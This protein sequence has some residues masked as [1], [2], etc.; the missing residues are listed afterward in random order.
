M[1]ELKAKFHTLD[2]ERQTMED[3]ME[4]LVASLQSTPVGLKGSVIDDEGFPR[5][6]ID[7]IQIRKWR[8]RLD[9]VSNDHKALMRTIETT[10]HAIHGAASD[11]ATTGGVPP[12]G[13]SAG[14]AS[15]THVAGD[16]RRNAAGPP[17][18][19]ADE[20]FV[21]VDDVTAGSPAATAGLQVGDRI[22]Q[23]GP[24]TAAGFTLAALGQLVA[25]NRGVT[26]VVRILRADAQLSVEL[27]PHPWAGQGLLG[28]HIVP[29]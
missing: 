11:G 13:G 19:A 8:Q 22:I 20:P 14:P 12:P 23:F 4:A 9:I 21:L 17:V 6:D 10:I 29:V 3:E 27:T 28:C 18:V 24:M 2:A 15:A 5:S 25:A 1:E 26:L 7:I 16:A